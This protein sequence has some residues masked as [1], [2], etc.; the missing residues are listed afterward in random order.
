[1]ID[2]LSLGL[3]DARLFYAMAKQ[4]V[5]DRN[6]WDDCVQEAAIHV[7]RLQQRGVEHPPAYYRKAARLRICEVAKRQTWFGYESHRGHPIDPLRRPH[8]SLDQIREQE[9]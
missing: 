5:D 1:V 7:W 2:A 6:I 9:A 8:D 3:P 4:F